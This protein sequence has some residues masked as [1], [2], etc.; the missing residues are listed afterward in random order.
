MF[1]GTDLS[2]AYGSSAYDP[3]PPMSSP[4]SS[5][6]SAPPPQAPSMDIPKATAS[7]AQAPDMMYAP[8]MAM[9]AQQPMA[10]VQ[11]PQDSFWDKVSSRKMD[12]LKLF[13][14][15]MVVLLGISMDRVAT[16]YLTTYVGKAFLSETQEFLVR[17]SYPVVVLVLLWFIKAMT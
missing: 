11:A 1:D 12:V 15:A 7:H 3:A 17:L 5:L 14:L 4:V 6:P 13:I 16:H 10:M 2:L 9:Y 8:P